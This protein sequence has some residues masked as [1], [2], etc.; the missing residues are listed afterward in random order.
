VGKKKNLD[1]DLASGWT[2]RRRKNTPQQRR[3]GRWGVNIAAPKEVIRLPKLFLR[4]GD[5]RREKTMGVLQKVKGDLGQRTGK[6]DPHSRRY[7]EVNQKL[8]KVKEQNKRSSRGHTKWS[9][10]LTWKACQRGVE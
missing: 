5:S 6:K 9:T 8:A 1:V 4:S 3:G 10:G 7:W 2:E